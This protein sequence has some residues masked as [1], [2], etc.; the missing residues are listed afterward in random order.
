MKLWVTQK[1]EKFQLVEE[2]TF[3]WKIFLYLN[4][5]LETES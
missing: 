4:L 2:K 5:M 3:F 1:D